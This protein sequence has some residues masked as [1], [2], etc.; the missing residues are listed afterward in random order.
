MKTLINIL[1]AGRSGTT[2]LDLMLGND[3]KSFSLGEV[4][5]LFRPFRKHHFRIDCNCG[6]QDCS[7]WSAVKNLKESKFHAKA[8]DVFDVDFLVDSSKNLA[9][10]ID[11]CDWADENHFRV[12]NIAIYKPLVSYVHSVWK[13]G[14]G[15]SA[16]V[17]RY[18]TYYARLISS[19][20]E[21]CTLSFSELVADPKQVLSTLTEI[22]GQPKN[23]NRDEF[24]SYEHHHLFGSGGTRNQ[25]RK[26]RSEVKAQ[27][28]YLPEFEKHRLEVERLLATDLDIK[29]ITNWFKQNDYKKKNNQLKCGRITGIRPGWYYYLKASNIWKKRFPDTAT[30]K[31]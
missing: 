5:A 6:N 24:W 11:T 19:G 23:L 22:S 29:E 28:D 16:A 30:V 18:K 26:G 10:V 15:I 2:M 12:L 8:F 17:D 21:C 31:Q 4:H 9:W 25:A 3:E 7:Y 20:L 1:G 27:E 13:R 14:E